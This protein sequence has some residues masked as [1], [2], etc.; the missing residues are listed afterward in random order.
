MK[1]ENRQIRETFSVETEY[2]IIEK[3]PIIRWEELIPYWPAICRAIFEV[4]IEN[5]FY[6]YAA[7]LKRPKGFV[8]SS[9]YWK[10]SLKNPIKVPL[11]D[12]RYFVFKLE[13][14]PYFIDAIREFNGKIQKNWLEEKTSTFWEDTC[15]VSIIH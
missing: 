12:A 9:H 5:D 7:T 11:S 2:G 6:P 10:M 3:V 15:I 14:K 13:E 8:A 4:L 1:I